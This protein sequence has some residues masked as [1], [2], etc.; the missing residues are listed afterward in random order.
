LEKA[1]ESDERL[2]VV[3]GSSVAEFERTFVS[4]SPVDVIAGAVNCTVA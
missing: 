1:I 2:S 4:I 3:E